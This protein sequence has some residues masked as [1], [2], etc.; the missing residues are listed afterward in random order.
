METKTLKVQMFN[1][2]LIGRQLPFIKMVAKIWYFSFNSDVFTQN[3]TKQKKSF[4]CGPNHPPSCTHGRR[5][6]G[7]WSVLLETAGSPDPWSKAST[8]R[9]L[10]WCHGCSPRQSVGRYLGEQQNGFKPRPKPPEA[11]DPGAV[12]PLSNE[13]LMSL[14]STCDPDTR[15]IPWCWRPGTD[16]Y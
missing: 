13:F 5:T 2:H 15:K 10:S 9:P 12:S 6:W 8:L 16:L 7:R 3:S 4:Q 11:G 1:R 14:T